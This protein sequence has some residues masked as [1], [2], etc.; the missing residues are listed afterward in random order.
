MT[1]RLTRMVLEIQAESVENDIN[2]GCLGFVD[3]KNQLADGRYC[4][5]VAQCL[6]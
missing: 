6:E 2:E 4:G 5:E 1:R 3:P